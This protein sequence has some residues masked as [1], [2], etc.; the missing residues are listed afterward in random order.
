MFAVASG[1]KFSH[2]TNH[3]MR[4]TELASFTLTRR[5]FLHGAGAGA[6]LFYIAPG[7]VVKGAARVSAN[8][9]IN[10]A[11]IGVG[12]RGGADLDEMPAEGRNIVALCDV[13][14]K[15]AAKSFAKY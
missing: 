14:S 3:I 4:K 5:Q 10:V 9:K 6:A 15:Y 1:S 8:E 13:D 11:G 12:S 2:K 7:S